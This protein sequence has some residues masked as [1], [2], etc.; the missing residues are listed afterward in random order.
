MFKFSKSL[1]VCSSLCLTFAVNQSLAQDAVY[2]NKIGGGATRL[3]GKISKVTPEGVTLG[4]R[5]IAA[6]EINRIS[7]GR[8]PG[9]INRLR[10][11]MVGGQYAECLAGID[12]LDN[13]PD[14]P[15]LQQEVGFMK[16]YSS[17]RLSLTQGTIS[18][19]VAVKAVS[20]FVRSAPNS[21]HLYPAIEQYGLLV[22]AGGKPEA[23]ARA[24]EKLR[25]AKWEE[26]RMRGQFLHGRMMSVMGEQEKAK[27][28]FQQILQE[29]STSPEAEKYKLLA[30]SEQARANGVTGDGSNGFE[31]TR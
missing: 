13:I 30:R 25:P 31:R 27:A 7:V 3:T 23:A 12:K 8:E 11:E 20:D 14:E 2:I 26:Y 21:L 28:D 17:A 29:S 15:L 24:F 18:N 1:I 4:D 9:A 22:Y 6:S 16:A 19:D 10:E 5:E